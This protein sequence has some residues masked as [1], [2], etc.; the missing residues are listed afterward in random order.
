MTDVKTIVKPMGTMFLISITLVENENRG[1]E[2]KSQTDF[3][4]IFSYQQK[5]DKEIK[6]FMNNL[7]ENIKFYELSCYYKNL[8]TC[9]LA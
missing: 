3:A 4:R 5:S 9:R 8:I 1:R 2:I 6:I 7:F